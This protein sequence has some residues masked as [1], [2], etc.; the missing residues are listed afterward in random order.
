MFSVLAEAVLHFWDVYAYQD[1]KQGV[2]REVH[3]LSAILL[4][5]IM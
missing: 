5:L 3:L 1:Q 4:I 2:L